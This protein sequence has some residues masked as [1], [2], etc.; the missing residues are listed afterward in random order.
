MRPIEPHY[1][2]PHQ[3]LRQLLSQRRQHTTLPSI[4]ET[5]TEPP[6]F[7]KLRISEDLQEPVE[8]SISIDSMVSNSQSVLVENP[9]KANSQKPLNEEAPEEIKTINEGF[10]SELVRPTLSSSRRRSESFK[11]PTVT[12]PSRKPKRR[13]IFD[14]EDD[15]TEPF[16]VNNTMQIPSSPHLLPFTPINQKRNH[17]P[18]LDEAEEVI[19]ALE[20][21][22]QSLPVPR[23]RTKKSFVDAAQLESPV[24]ANEVNLYWSSSRASAECN[25]VVRQGQPAPSEDQQSSEQDS[26]LITPPA[27]SSRHHRMYPPVPPQS[28]DDEDD[29][30]VKEIPFCMNSPERPRFRKERRVSSL[31]NPGEVE[32]HERAGKKTRAFRTAKSY[33]R[34]VA[35]MWD[36]LEAERQKG[37]QWA[38]SGDLTDSIR[39]A[40]SD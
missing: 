28:S 31:V 20:A 39:T 25:A 3:K 2:P 4:A 37:P 16:P 15:E 11:D 34:D 33:A 9:S 12:T 32:L 18:A 21:P 29:S 6:N 38:V 24:R 14:I 17:A 5:S 35:E 23:K 36:E 8:N 30:G 26:T 22:L 13:S 40:H 7:E 1:Q 19:D 27:G 10:K